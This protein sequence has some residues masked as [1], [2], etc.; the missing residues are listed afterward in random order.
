MN[1][2]VSTLSILSRQARLLETLVSGSKTE[3][4]L[5]EIAQEAARSYHFLTTRLMAKEQSD[6]E[7]LAKL[8]KKFSWIENKAIRKF[9]KESTVGPTRSIL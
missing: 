9:Y 7:L 3:K 8:S 6:R 4:Q 1:N 5:F 2:D